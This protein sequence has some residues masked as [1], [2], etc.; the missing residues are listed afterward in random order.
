MNTKELQEAFGQ[1]EHGTF[2]IFDTIGIPHPYCITPSHIVVAHDRYC[3]Q[4]GVEA[5][6]AAEKTGA[7]CGVRG[8]TLPFDQ[9]EH[10]LLVACKPGTELKGNEELKD[11]LV[12]SKD[13]CEAKGYVGF[14]FVEKDPATIGGPNG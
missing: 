7:K 3:G 6:R 12:A 9:H 5:I 13:K 8:C 14:A 11:Y 10:A 4:L 1:S 2:A